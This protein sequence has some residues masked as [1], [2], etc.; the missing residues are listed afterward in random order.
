MRRIAVSVIVLFCCTTLQAQLMPVEKVFAFKITDYIKQLNDSISLVQVVKPGSWPITIIEK[1]LGVL[2]HCS[3][4]G[5]ELDTASIGWGRCQLIKG[6]YYYF[7]IHLYKNQQIKEGDLLYTKLTTQVIYNGRLVDVMKHAVELTRVTDEKFLQPEDMF[8]INRQK[9]QALLDS[10][11]ADIHY[12]GSVMMQQIPDQNQLIKGGI[13][14]G[15]KLFTAMQA[16]TR[17]ELEQFL[18][19]IIA[20]PSIYAGNTW[21]IS[22]I[23][24]T[25]M[26]SETPRV[27]ENEEL[28]MKKNEGRIGK[29]E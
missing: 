19:Y 14:D 17:A 24:A 13:Y 5:I 2:K 8:T 26:V 21:K 9:E 25:W 22:E 16:A 23:F 29:D 3:K 12:T 6:E 20:R 27:I 10:M 15:K 11:I 28:K 4:K 1:Q 18:N 7:A